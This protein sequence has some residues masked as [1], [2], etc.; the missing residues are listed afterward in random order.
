MFVVSCSLCPVC[1]VGFALLVACCLC[2]VGC[3]LV[4]VVGCLMSAVVCC[5]LLVA[6]ACLVCCVLFAY[7]CVVSWLSSVVYV[8]LHVLC[9][10]R[11]FCLRRMSVACSRSCVVCCWPCCVCCV[12]LVVACLF[13]FGGS[14]LVRLLCVVC[15]FFLRCLG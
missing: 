2:V 7:W 15:S 13:V 1:F 14:R 5:L 8:F 10:L 9:G 6:L 3:C 4:F 11:C 12:L